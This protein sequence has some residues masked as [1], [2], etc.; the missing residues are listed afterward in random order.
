MELIVEMNFQIAYLILTKDMNE[1]CFLPKCFESMFELCLVGQSSV[2]DE[3][4][5]DK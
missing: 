3:E 1:N 5:D 2:M 4:E